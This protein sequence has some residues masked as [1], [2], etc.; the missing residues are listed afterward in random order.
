MIEV[1]V[2]GLWPDPKTGSHV[3]LLRLPDSPKCLP[4]WI[5][6][7]EASAIAMALRGQEFE[8]P[9]TH[10]LLMHVIGGLGAEL[11]RVVITTIEDNT[12]YARLFLTRGHEILSIDARPSDS[13][14]LA[15][16]AGC[17]ILLSDELLEDQRDHLVEL[18][19]EVAEPEGEDPH[20]SS[21]QALEAL[22]RE[23]ERGR[24]GGEGGPGR[25]G[26][27]GES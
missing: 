1:T 11:S 26:G 21:E 4:I 23:V 3:L 6:M 13:V 14:A 7:N 5:G 27:E 9:L 24:A 10:D 25:P 20:A 2:G 19:A 16:R 22:L 17:P 15:V 12:F 8:R 18:Q